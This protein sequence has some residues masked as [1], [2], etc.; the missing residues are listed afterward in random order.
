[1]SGVQLYSLQ[2]LISDILR[3]QNAARLVKYGYIFLVIFDF[4]FPRWTVSVE[5]QVSEISYSSKDFNDLL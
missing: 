3:K 2:A 4:F 5:Y 1:M